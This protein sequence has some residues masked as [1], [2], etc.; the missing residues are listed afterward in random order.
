M[1]AGKQGVAHESDV[2]VGGS[3]KQDDATRS[4]AGGLHDLQARVAKLDK[5]A[6]FHK[7]IGCR[8]ALDL[9][10]PHLVHAL[11]REVKEGRIGGRDDKGYALPQNTAH[12]RDAAQVVG[13]AV[14]AHHGTDLDAGMCGDEVASELLAIPGRVDHHGLG[15]GDSEVGVGLDRT[16]D[17]ALNA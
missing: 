14:G 10:T 8:R 7:A 4:M 13:M 3:G 12:T 6:L 11:D 9:D 1:T 2:A 16:V 17:L 5:V 15:S